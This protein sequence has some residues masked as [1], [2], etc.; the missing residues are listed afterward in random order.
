MQELFDKELL[1]LTGDSEAP[2]NIL[3]GVSGGI[4]SMCMAHLFLNS[5]VNVKFSVAHVNFSLRGEESDGDEQLV[6]EWCAKHGIQFYSNKFDTLQYAEY[7]SIST[8]MAA[9]ELRYSWFF[10][11]MEK[12]SINYLAVAHNLNDSVE[13]FF[14]NIL[15]GTGLR[16]LSGIRESNGV[17]IRPLLPFT[18]AQ[19]VQFVADNDIHFREDRTNNETHY[20]RNKV[21][22]LVFPYFS[23]INPSFLNTINTEIHRFGEVEDIMEE[24]FKM[25]EGA[26]YK[27]EG[28]VLYVDIEA[29]KKEKFRSYWLYRILCDYGFN[30]TQ[31]SQIDI[32]LN[33]QSGKIFHSDEYIL[34]RDREYLKV[35]PATEEEK[36]PE[37][38]IVVFPRPSNFN[39]K[40]A[41]KD[42][43][44]YIDGKNVTFPLKWRKWNPADRFKPLG[45]KGF[46]K[47]SDF[48]TDLKLDVK[49]KQQQIVVTTLDKQGVEQIVCVLGKR[50]DDRYKVTAVTKQIIAISI[51]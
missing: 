17:I 25:R 47:L 34:V 33:S 10:M 41:S 12:H 28:G 3:I 44:L 5:K 43:I 38:K 9:R 2:L 24:Q 8:Q 19:I 1:R 20:L 30:D 26:L 23:S 27:V 37:V 46:K 4:D 21:R 48:F 16:G 18:R 39:P 42:G 6:Q 32:A 49:Q 50:I 7:N 13:T 45:M 11:L 14:L 31:V 35:Y 29:L 22:N 36:L 15:R 51:K 40:E